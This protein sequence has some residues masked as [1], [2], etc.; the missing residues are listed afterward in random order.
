MTNKILKS[1][2]P[3]IHHVILIFDVVTMALEDHIDNS[4]LPLVVHHAV[5]QGYLMLNKYYTLI[6]DSIVYQVVMSVFFIC[7]SVHLLAFNHLLQFSTSIMRQ[8]I[9]L[10]QNG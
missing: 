7:F 9:F 2:V 6:D 10:V 3:L 4:T 1:K 8:H 5:L